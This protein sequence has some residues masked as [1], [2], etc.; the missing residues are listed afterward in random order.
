MWYQKLK[1]EKVTF[2][3][4]NEQQIRIC[5]IMEGVFR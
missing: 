2:L 3:K 5:K 1:Q 4:P